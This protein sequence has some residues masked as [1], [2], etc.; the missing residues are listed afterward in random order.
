MQR[1]L[2]VGIGLLLSMP[3]VAADTFAPDPASVRRHGPAYR[4]PQAGWTVIHIEGD[5]YPRG[6]QHGKL[7]ATEIGNY[8]RSL[9]AQQSKAAPNDGWKLTRTVVNAAFLR[10]FDR[11]LLDEMQGIADGASAGGAKFDERP[12]DLLDIV[13]INVQMEYETLDHALEALPTGLEGVKFPKAAA[14]PV[15][16]P[17]KDHCSAFA[18]TGPATADGKLVIGHITMSGLAN[19][20]DTNIWIDVKP[21]KGNRVVMQGFPGAIWSAQ[22]YYLNSAGIILTETTIAQTRYNPDGVPLTARCRKAMQYGNTIDDVVKILSE[23]NNGLYTNEWLIGDANTNE[24][25]MLE[26]GT[27]TTKLWRSSKNEW[28]LPGT[29]GFY[30]GCNNTKDLAVRIDTLPGL[31]GRPQD[32]SWRPSDRD[33]AWLKLYDQNRG[34]VDASFGKRAFATPPLAAHSSLDAKVTTSEMAKRLDSH[35]LFGP[36]Y[37]RVWEASVKE[38]KKYYEVRDFV[39]NDWTVITTAAP[40]KAE[41][42][43]VADFVDKIPERPTDPHTVPAWQGTLLPKSDADVWLTAGFAGYER[44]VALENAL[45]E[46]SDGTLTPGDTERVQ[47]ALFQNQATYLAAKV[48]RPSWLKSDHAKPS[49]SPLTLELDRDRWHTEQAHYG[50]LAFA[51]LRGL[52]GDD[53]F[54]DSMDEFGRVHAGKQITIADFTAAVGK[55][56]GKDVAEFLSRWQPPSVAG[57]AVSVVGWVRHPDE[58]VIVYGTQSDKVGNKAAAELLQSAVRV[59]WSNI[60][61]PT[62]ADQDVSDDML[63]GKHVVLIGRPIANSVTKRFVKAFSV[64]FGQDS[65]TVNEKVYAHERTA[66]VAAGVNPI[67]AKYS[68][69]AIAG[70]SADATYCAAESIIDAPSAEVLI[71]PRGTA[72]VPIVIQHGL[73]QLSGTR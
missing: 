55:T 7:L 8:V 27:T 59:K 16:T 35:A 51:A 19:A 33:K 22:D 63:K 20:L 67:D 24:I 5:A 12:L 28:L 60:V 14:K 69:V 56:S 36:P 42:V 23:K 1:Y 31:Q 53:T 50:V 6:Y 18:A 49:V 30:W 65:A 3:V 13:C 25:A 11:E 70:F 45:R 38:D 9:A 73:Q 66:I 40:A 4:Y 37:G 71:F 54:G 41:Q 26:L 2:L 72:A 46:K 64:T 48:Q 21:T 39:P 52:I 32:I 62:V 68:V 58:T 29:E 44:V 17:A 43:A 57:R 34:K 61:I 47:L 15:A 10:K